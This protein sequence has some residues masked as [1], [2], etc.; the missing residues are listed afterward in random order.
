MKLTVIE[1]AGQPVE[2]GASASF[3]ESGGIIGRSAGCHL[4]L[5][6]PEGRIARLQAVLS[7][8]QDGWHVRNASATLAIVVG[9]QHL[10]LN[11]ECR[12]REGEL[13]R[14]GAFLLRSEASQSMQTPPPPTVTGS[15]L[16]GARP[17]AAALGALAP[18]ASQE[19]PFADLLGGA[20]LSAPPPS[21]T[22]RLH[23][24]ESSTPGS[25]RAWVAPSFFGQLPDAGTSLFTRQ[26]QGFSRER[27]P[28]HSLQ[29]Q[30]LDPLA[31]FNAPAHSQ[32]L[33]QDLGPSILAD[34]ALTTLP[35]AGI[36]DSPVGY[37]MADQ[38]EIGRT[39]LR[40]GEISPPDSTPAPASAPTTPPVGPAEASF[41]FEPHA[42][43]FGELTEPQEARGRTFVE[44]PAPVQSIVEAAVFTADL[45]DS[46]ATP[47]QPVEP[48]EEPLQP[49]RAVPPTHECPLSED[50][51]RDEPVAAEQAMARFMEAAGIG[52]VSPAPLPLDLRMAQLGRLL[53]MFADGTVRLLASRAL[54]KR[55]VRGELTRVMDAANNPF[56][57]L[58]SGE[59][60]LIQMFGQ[61]LPGFLPAEQAIRGALDDLQHH[62]LGVMAG[63]R[64]ALF[65]LIRKFDPRLS[66]IEHAP[67]HLLDRLF[68]SRVDSRRWRHYRSRYQ[69][70]LAQAQG[71]DFQRLFGESFLRAY[72]DETGRCAAA[73]PER[74][75]EVSA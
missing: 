58:P 2:Q 42:S 50:T 12:L 1:Y 8:R 64:T 74:K 6:D 20:P 26:G 54:L 60:V 51:S 14:I 28:A 52:Q 32:D 25:E 37:E 30:T 16:T 4:T 48:H 66:E 35:P 36:D 18:A 9:S 55:E 29:S 7:H 39:A 49:V 68:P 65:E 44:A 70:L 22:P 72:E 47:S 27:S 57:I 63:T 31:L 38:V 17:E 19:N 40:W 71:N 41:D 3:C 46:S 5:N 11:Q 59:A 10:E 53:R 62:Q 23:L 69:T 21:D 67:R 34:P 24:E 56:K 45:P 61:H 73:A 13:L 75:A 43:V 33:L 15:T